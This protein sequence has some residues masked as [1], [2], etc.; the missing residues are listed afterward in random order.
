MT[1]LLLLLF[2]SLNTPINCKPIQAA[3]RAA[4]GSHVAAASP[5]VGGRSG[6]AVLGPVQRTIR[7]TSGASRAR[8]IAGSTVKGLAGPTQ[9]TGDVS[10]THGTER[11]SRGSVAIYRVDRSIGVLMPGAGILPA[12]VERTI[13]PASTQQIQGL[14]QLTYGLLN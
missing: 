9:T 2:S 7:A 1:L 12:I 11:Y 5:W 4:C 8:L 6:S 10:E 14:I 3:F 13:S